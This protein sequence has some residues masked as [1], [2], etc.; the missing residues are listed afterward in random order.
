MVWDGRKK[1]RVGRLSAFVFETPISV[2]LLNA[3]GVFFATVAL[4]SRGA[5]LMMACIMPRPVAEFG[6]CS[7]F[8]Q[9][10]SVKR[11][12]ALAGAFFLS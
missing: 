12:E 8:W 7:I 5:A 4:L 9:Q 10:F 2:A 11:G 1:G 6:G 3:T